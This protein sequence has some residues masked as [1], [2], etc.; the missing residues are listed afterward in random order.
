MS[1]ARYPEYK[2]SGV[3]WLGEVPAPW[4]LRPFWTLFRRTKRTGYVDE[5]LLSVYRDHGVVPKASRDDNNNKPSDDL[6]PYQLVAPGDLAINKMKA[7]QGSVA[8]SEHRGIVSPAYFVY[9][10]TH[11]ENPR[12]LHYLFRSPRYITGYLSLSKGIR[13]NQWDLEPQDHSRMPVVLPPSVEQTAIATFLD[14][15]TAKIDRLVAE[16]EKLIALL[17]EKRQAVISHAV[18]K[19]LNPNVPMKDSGVEWL[20]E[21]PGHWVVSS[22]RHSLADIFNGLTA[23][24]IDPSDATVPV[25]RIETISNGTINFE[26]VGFISQSDARSDRKLKFG[27]ICF[28]NINSLKMIGNCAIYL[29]GE[30]IYGGM[31]LLVLRPVDAIHPRYL[32][33]II[34]SDGFRETVE[35]HAKPA[36]NQASIS[37]SSL[38]SLGICNPSKEEQTAIATF[39]DRETGKLDTLMVQ[40][41]TAITLLQERR[42][43]LISAAVTGQIDVRGLAGGAN[44]PD[45][46]AASAYP[47]SV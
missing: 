39:L 26:K 17:Q 11:S 43:A 5:Q 37:Q 13:V 20:G 22:L 42:T 40:A 31:N 24:Q 27:D 3:Q 2:A 35:S 16:Q 19:G 36:I 1:F 23:D 29:G 8:I 33:W 30:D 7:W 46:V 45:S 47:A 10:A 38:L 18:T 6:S 21:V 32:Y 41:R 25:T 44:A 4:R 15:E 28:S 9:E 12:Y 34:R 14:R